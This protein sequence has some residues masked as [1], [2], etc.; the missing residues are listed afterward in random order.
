MEHVLGS[1][2]LISATP[3]AVI[4]EGVDTGC[5]ANTPQAGVSYKRTRST[6]ALDAFDLHGLNKDE[7]V[8]TI[9]S[10]FQLCQ[11]LNRDEVVVENLEHLIEGGS[12]YAIAECVSFLRSAVIA[13]S[14]RM[15]MAVP[16]IALEK[17]REHFDLRVYLAPH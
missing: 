15:G 3:V 6:L 11:P 14:R 2:E 4:A 1:E 9:E 12:G 17:R 16:H 5:P 10:M 13:T 7:A 8:D